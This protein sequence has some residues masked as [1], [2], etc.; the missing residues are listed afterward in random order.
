MKTTGSNKLFLPFENWNKASRLVNKS[1]INV[2]FHTIACYQDVVS[3]SP[4][5]KILVRKKLIFYWL[6]IVDLICIY[7]ELY[8]SHSYKRMKNVALLLLSGKR[9]KKKVLM[10]CLFVWKW[11]NTVRYWFGFYYL[12]VRNTHTKERWIQL[13]NK[14]H[15]GKL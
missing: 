12:T 10:N 14:K 15:F 5:S 4:I 8:F 11:I 9:K 7:V 13:W 1:M 6:K 3:W 2:S